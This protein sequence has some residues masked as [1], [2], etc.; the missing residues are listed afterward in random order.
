MQT[1]SVCSKNKENNNSAGKSICNSLLIIASAHHV[2]TCKLSHQWAQDYKTTEL[3]KFLKHLHLVKRIYATRLKTKNKKKKKLKERKK[4]NFWDQNCP[5][6]RKWRTETKIPSSSISSSSFTTSDLMIRFCNLTTP[7]KMIA[8]CLQTGLFDASL[9]LKIP[10]AAAKWRLARLCLVPVAPCASQLC[11]LLYLPGASR[12]AERQLGDASARFGVCLSS[13]G[14]EVSLVTGLEWCPRAWSGLL[15]SCPAS[16][17][18]CSRTD[19]FA[20]FRNQ[21]DNKDVAKSF[22]EPKGRAVGWSLFPVQL[23][24][25][26]PPSCPLTRKVPCPNLSACSG[27]SELGV[28]SR[29]LPGY[30]FADTALPASSL[31]WGSRNWAW[32]V[33]RNAVSLPILC[34]YY[35]PKDIASWCRGFLSHGLN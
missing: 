7:R 4:K 28:A 34:K 6:I 20:S 10:P 22:M 33:M 2:I 25:V 21:P 11:V 29:C 8:G 16:R 35:S 30:C 31:S 27:G 5:L 17:L 12:G 32:W 18:P 1:P 13:S 23:W 9:W 19:G 26:W 15:L 24:F 14:R 3:L